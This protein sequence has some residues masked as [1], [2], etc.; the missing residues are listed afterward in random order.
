MKPI[1]LMDEG[2]R[3]KVVIAGE[4]FYLYISPTSLVVTVPRENDPH[5]A[6]TR[7]IVET[8]AN[9]VTGAREELAK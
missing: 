3:R 2:V 9:T 8:I 6:E 5:M 7:M 1:E 4:N